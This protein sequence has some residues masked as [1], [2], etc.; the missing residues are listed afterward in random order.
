MTSKVRELLDSKVREQENLKKAELKALQA[1]INPHFL[2]NTLDTIVWMAEANQTDKVIEIVRALSSFFRIALSRGKDWISIRQEIEHVRS[3]L[4]IQKI[5]YR[6]ILDYEIEIDDSILDG[7]ILK[8]IL[9]PLAENALYHGIK[10]KRNGGTICVRARRAEQNLILLEVQDD[11]VGFTPYKLSKIQETLAA[12]TDEILRSESGFGLEN[13]HK[14][15]QLYYGKQYGVSV[16]SQ[17]LEG[18]RVTV[19]IPLQEN[20]DLTN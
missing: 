10:N 15:I 12:N 7:T 16:E 18:T 9:Q 13:V 6:D 1:Q 19:A 5:R 20:P 11:G 17:Y 14:R 8:L 4:Y 3:Y 2:Y